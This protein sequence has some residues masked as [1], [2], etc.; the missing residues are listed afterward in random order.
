MYGIVLYCIA[1]YIYIAD[2]TPVV[3]APGTFEFVEYLVALVEFREFPAQRFADGVCIDRVR[4][5]PQVPHLQV[6]VVP[7]QQ[8]LA[9]VAESGVAYATDYVGEETFLLRFSVVVKY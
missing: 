8:V 4:L 5:Y 6:Q 7:G 1:Y 9:V 2:G 3:V